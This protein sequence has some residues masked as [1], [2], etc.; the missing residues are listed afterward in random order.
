MLSSQPVEF[1]SDFE[2]GQGLDVLDDGNEESL[3]GVHGHPDVVARLV[4]DRL[5]LGVEVAVEN[6]IL[7]QGQR[8]SIDDEGHVG[9]LDG[10]AASDLNRFLELGPKLNEPADVELVTVAKMRYRQSLRP[11][12]I[13]PKTTRRVEIISLKF[14]LHFLARVPLYTGQA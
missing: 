2:D 10:A 1:R 5:L 11:E 14:N 12:K 9:E 13:S 3:S 6:G 4:G 8:T 7:Q